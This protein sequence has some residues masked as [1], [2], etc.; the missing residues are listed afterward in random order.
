M[1]SIICGKCH[2]INEV[3]ATSC[4]KCGARFCPS[5]RLV[6]D[7]PNASICQHCGKKDLSFRPGKYGVSSYAGTG[8]PAPEYT[9]GKALCQSC[10]NKID[11]GVRKCPYCGQLGQRLTMTPTQG[12]GVMKPASERAP[13]SA[14][15]AEPDTTSSLQKRCPR[16]GRA[17]PLDSSLCPKCGR[18]GG[19]GVVGGGT[20]WKDKT[21]EGEVYRRMEE[22]G[23]GSAAEQAMPHRQRPPQEIYPQM[24]AEQAAPPEMP[25]MADQRTCPQCGAPVP[26][27]SKICP[28]CGWNR[29][30]RE[31]TK[32]IPRAEDFYKARESAAGG[33]PYA[34]YL[35]DQ[36]PYAA[37]LPDQQP[38]YGQPAVQPYEM[39]YPPPPP[40]GMELPYEDDRKKKKKE[41]KPRE[42]E[43]YRAAPKP[44]Q[45]ILPILLALLAIGAVIVLGVVFILDQLKTPAQPV[46]PP[47]VM[48]P[49]SVS[50]APVITDIQYKDIARTSAVVTWKTDKKS[51]SIVVYCLE[52]GDLCENAK[53][54]NLVTDHSVKLT[55]LETDKGYH[56]TVKSRLDDNP[57]SADA[58]VEHTQ[59]LRTL[60]IPDATPPKITKVN[61]ANIISS[62][63]MASASI[64]WVTDEPSSSQVAYGTSATHGSLQPDPADTNLS[65]YHEIEL[66]GLPLQ[67]TIH[68]KVISKDSAGNETSSPDATF[69]TPAPAGSAIGNMA[70]DFT[71]ACA[72]GSQVTLSALHGKKVIINFWN[73][74]CHY[75][76][77]EMP[78][79]QAVW[80]NYSEDNVA[81]LMINS[82]AGGFGTNRNEAVGAEI[83]SKSYTFT[84]PL[85]A[86]GT[87]A[88]AYNVTSFIPVTFF[89]DSTGIIK[90][91][92]DGAFN[93]AGEIENML[94]SY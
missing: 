94:N 15:P 43:D 48:P 83:T 5:C 85:D 92:Q 76:M 72:D 67:T 75:C 93:N 55:G 66:Y 27:R 80:E 63:T 73:M 91:K 36:Q 30:P 54:D 17:I 86:T 16:C 64:S 90:K 26:D 7:S 52:G 41:K 23:S 89:V 40:I 37:Y 45:P 44:K 61:V 58:T 70:P 8:A 60:G 42:Y 87:V 65:V 56:V 81:M 68:Y 33:Q 82:A 3:S 21:F 2:E 50:K 59:V 88:Q 71:L 34:T 14:P 1:P 78:Y 31:S 32:I 77:E 28:N 24:G 62:T 39:A 25:A 35:P 57:N 13:F 19:T 12:H 4:Q 46:V 10:G 11:P 9:A 20:N 51:N 74:Q 49:A 18:Y 79:F 38:Y 22:R 6:I 47:P 84:V 53:D 29:L 69:V